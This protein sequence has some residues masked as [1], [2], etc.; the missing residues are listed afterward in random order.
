MILGERQTRFRRHLAYLAGIVIAYPLLAAA[1]LIGQSGREPLAA[2]R[3]RGLAVCL[4]ELGLLAALVPW[5]LSAERR[6]ARRPAATVLW[7]TAL[8]MAVSYGLSLALSGSSAGWALWPALAAQLMA[9]AFA[10][11]LGGLWRLILA[12]SRRAVVAQVAAMLVGGLMLSS[13]FWSPVLLEQMHAGAWKRLAIALVV[14]WNPILN[15]AG[16]AFRW[17][18]SV[19]PIGYR[20]GVLASYG[21]HYFPYGLVA[22]SYGTAGVV[23]GLAGRIVARRR[24]FLAGRRM[25]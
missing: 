23:F 1:L 22:L 2:A 18:L 20:L 6:R 7:R 21:F 3:G 24:E 11:L 12:V 13:L 9:V 4:L 16:S 17:D 10:I 14:W 5:L 8:F 19:M 15:V 25:P